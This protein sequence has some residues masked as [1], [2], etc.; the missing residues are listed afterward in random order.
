MSDTEQYLATLTVHMTEG[1]TRVFHTTPDECGEALL[2]YKTEGLLVIPIHDH[3]NQKTFIS[4][5]HNI[6]SI[7]TN[8]RIKWNVKDGG[9]DP[10]D[11]I[12]LG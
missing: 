12:V 10:P 6:I 3:N 1:M 8:I 11:G 9:G 4:S 7:S 2:G 5:C